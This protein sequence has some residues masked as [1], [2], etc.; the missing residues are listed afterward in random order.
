[1]ELTAAELWS[2]IL[3]VVQAGLPEQAFRTWLAGTKASGLSEV[4]LQ[5]EA[6][7]QFHV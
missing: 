3:Q 2:R 4:E 5:V 6:P 1:M 7:N